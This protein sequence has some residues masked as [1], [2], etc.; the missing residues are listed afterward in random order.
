MAYKKW[1]ASAAQLKP[2]PRYASKL[3]S[4]FINCLMFGGK[5]SIA[6]RMFYEAL[7]II[8]QRVKDATPLE[9][10]EA[11]IANTKPSIEV[12]SR[13]VGGSNYQVPMQI[14]S[15]RQQALAFRWIIQAVRSKSGRS[16]ASYLAD[17]LTAA[18]KKEGA[19]I[20]S[21]ENMH[22]MAEANRAFAHF[23]WR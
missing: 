7:D 19:A 20:T 10:F 9:V 2:D 15:K 12:R 6:Q 22:R 16:T 1:T 18:Y 13:R 11:A 5:K 3:A 21:R 14:Q 17:E 8:A 23:A 4:K